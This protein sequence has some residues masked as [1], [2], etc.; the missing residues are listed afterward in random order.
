MKN[1]IRFGPS[2]KNTSYNTLMKATSQLI[3]K[4]VL[5]LFNRFCGSVWSQ[6]KLWISQKLRCG[7]SMTNDSRSMFTT[8]N[9][10]VWKFWLLFCWR[11]DSE[12]KHR[13]KYGLWRFTASAVLM[14]LNWSVAENRE[15]SWRAKLCVY[16]SINIPTLT[17]SNKLWVMTERTGS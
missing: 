9:T 3:V 16:Q 1:L 10:L 7:L 11:W 14:T 4:F 8:N 13:W 15:L 6:H 12:W 17:C 5:Y 2:E